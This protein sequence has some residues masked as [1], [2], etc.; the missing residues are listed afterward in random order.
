VQASG[1]AVAVS[2]NAESN[3]ATSAAAAGTATSVLPRALPAAAA[4]PTRYR[5]SQ[6]AKVEHTATRP[7]SNGTNTGCDGP[8]CRRQF[9]ALTLPQSSQGLIQF[10]GC[11]PSICPDNWTGGM[12]LKQHAVHRVPNDFPTVAILRPLRNA[13]RAIFGQK[14][15]RSEVLPSRHGFFFV[16]NNSR[17]Y[18]AASEGTNKARPTTRGIPFGF[19]LLVSLP[20]AGPA[21][22]SSRHRRRYRNP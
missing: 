18:R 9:D 2:T 5:F 3:D 15:F 17:R 1:P 7:T 6:N 4:E 11:Q 21:T 13:R 19:T 14:Q 16:A 12:I 10:Q 8:C 20:L 22:P